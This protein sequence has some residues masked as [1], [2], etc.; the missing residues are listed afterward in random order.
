MKET[1]TCIWLSPG[2]PS[3]AGMVDIRSE[4]AAEGGLAGADRA[5]FGRPDRR[6]GDHAGGR[7]EQGD[8]WPL[9]RAL[10]GKCIGGLQRD[11]TRPGRKPPLRAETI[12]QV[13]HKTLHDK[14]TA[15][16]HWSIRKMAAATGLSYTR[17][18]RI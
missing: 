18:Q 9:A 16:T 10:L 2:G 15:G 7:G 14:P 5:A 13:V 6:D 3:D 4:H 11:G 1:E 8:G 12:Q 17:A